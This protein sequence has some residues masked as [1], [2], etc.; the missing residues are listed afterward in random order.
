MRNATPRARSWVLAAGSVILVLTGCDKSP[1]DPNRPAS[2]A[3][4]GRRMSYEKLAFASN[5]GGRVSIFIQELDGLAVN[6]KITDPPVGSGD[7]EPNFAPG[8][9]TIVF[10][11]WT[12]GKSELFS[13]NLNAKAAKQLTNF[14][15]TVQNPVYSPDGAR[16]AFTLDQDGQQDVYVM[17]AN[18]TNV[19]QLT[20]TEADDFNP[21]WTPDGNKVVYST[22][23]YGSFQVGTR[24]RSQNIYNGATGIV[25]ACPDSWCDTPRWSPSGQRII[26]LSSPSR[27]QTPEL[28]LLDLST[29]EHYVLNGTYGG[30]MGGWKP[31]GNKFVYVS[32]HQFYAVETKPNGLISPFAPLTG[33]NLWP[34]W[35]R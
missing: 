21:T 2:D 3:L 25:L 32:Q 11:R 20:N 14:G 5:M 12:D 16:I 29:G 31:D 17:D 34:T 19:R 23:D 18:G 33:T 24:I 1:T 4:G 28:K 8:N 7:S 9:K 22:A 26:Y 13:T 10:V 27:Y 30:Y 6:K 15:G 35:S